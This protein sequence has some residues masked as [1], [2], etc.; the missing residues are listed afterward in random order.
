MEVRK[1][2]EALLKEQVLDDEGLNTLMCK[3]EC[4]NNGRPITKV[5]DNPRDLNIL[6]P[7]HLLL[8]RAGTAIPPGV[9]SREDNYTCR[10]LHQV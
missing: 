6:T 10:R 1:V 2:M 3:V 8:L 5:S 9:F 4:I 7:S